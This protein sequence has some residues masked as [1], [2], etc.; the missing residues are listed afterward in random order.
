MAGGKAE[1]GS[2]KE[3]KPRDP[4]KAARTQWV[5]NPPSVA[6]KTPADG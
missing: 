6:N 5:D 3:M 1:Q 2:G 4:S